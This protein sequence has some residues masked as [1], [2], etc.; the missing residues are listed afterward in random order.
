MKKIIN[1]KRYDTDKAVCIGS[2][3]H[4]HAGSINYVNEGLY[5]T[6]RSGKYFIAG[7]GGA[8]TKYS[9]RVSNNSWSGGDRI[10]PLSK[11]DAFEWAQHY[12]DEKDIENHFHDLIQD[13]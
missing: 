13:A 6:P 11:E 1:G 2:Y 4:S 7:S 5:V 3:K 8:N 12:L 10:Q 9:Q